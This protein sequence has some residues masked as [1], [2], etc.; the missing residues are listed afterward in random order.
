MD[1]AFSDL[2]NSASLLPSSNPTPN[3]NTMCIPLEPEDE[4]YEVFNCGTL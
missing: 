2:E 3:T 1:N 4:N